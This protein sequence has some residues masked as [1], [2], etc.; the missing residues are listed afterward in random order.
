MEKGLRLIAE[1]EVHMHFVNRNCSVI[2]VVSTKK[3]THF[4][5]PNSKPL[6]W[7]AYVFPR[8][9]RTHLAAIWKS[10]AM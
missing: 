9:F 7:L 10:H 8:P 2:V 1:Q 3:V 5:R 4:Q 6:E